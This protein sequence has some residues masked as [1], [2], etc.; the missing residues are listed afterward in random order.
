MKDGV[1]S[2]RLHVKTNEGKLPKGARIVFF[3]GQIDPWSKI[4]QHV[5][6]WIVD[7]WR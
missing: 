7:H 6:P 3:E 5:S 1:F 2:F 4:A